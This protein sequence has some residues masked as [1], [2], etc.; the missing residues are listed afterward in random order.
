MIR[1]FL[2]HPHDTIGKSGNN[3]VELTEHFGMRD[4]SRILLHR[5]LNQCKQPLLL[6]GGWRNCFRSLGWRELGWLCQV[7]FFT[8]EA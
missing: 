7:A 1:F 4:W 5:L 6:Y 8:K 2:C 3:L